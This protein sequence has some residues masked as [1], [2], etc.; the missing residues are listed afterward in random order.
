MEGLTKWREET[1]GVKRRSR[2]SLGYSQEVVTVRMGVERNHCANQLIVATS[3]LVSQVSV[4][5]RENIS[6][7]S[8]WPVTSLKI[9]ISPP[10]FQFLFI[11]FPK[12]FADGAIKP[13]TRLH[14]QS[15]VLPGVILVSDAVKSASSCFHA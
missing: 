7:F 10:S 6:S 12:G 3:Q 8:F 9:V 4:S 13:F 11:L 2:P 5:N 1:G 15:A 14:R